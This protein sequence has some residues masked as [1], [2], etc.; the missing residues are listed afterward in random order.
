M[1]VLSTCRIFRYN[2]RHA[3]VK[4]SVQIEKAEAAGVYKLTVLLLTKSGA[5]FYLTYYLQEDQAESFIQ[6]LTEAFH[7]VGGSE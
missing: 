6:I 5:D 4:K 2:L 7:D 3:T 1:H